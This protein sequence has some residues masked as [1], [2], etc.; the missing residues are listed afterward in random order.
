M[1]A[2]AAEQASALNFLPDPKIYLK[3][4]EKERNETS[5]YHSQLLLKNVRPRPSK[6]MQK[7]YKHVLDNILRMSSHIYCS[8][9][10]KEKVEWVVCGYKGIHL[11]RS[12]PS[13][14]AQ[15]TR[16][17][18][19]TQFPPTPTPFLFGLPSTQTLDSIKVP[20]AQ[21]TYVHIPA[22][23]DCWMDRGGQTWARLRWVVWS[24]RLS[25]ILQCSPT[26]EPPHGLSDVEKAT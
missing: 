7:Q 13:A 9:E 11:D 12:S 15:L 22:Q 14:E 19:S 10:Q 16:C 2:R 25:T 18:G 17:S 3:I 24:H 6:K 23:A 1:I 26:P 4:R 21:H 8:W 5:F 20:H